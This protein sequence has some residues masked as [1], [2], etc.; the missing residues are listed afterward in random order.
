MLSL[1]FNGHDVALY[2][3]Q[4][5][6]YIKIEKIKKLFYYWQV[7]YNLLPYVMYK[8]VIKKRALKNLEKMPLSVQKKFN[9]LVANLKETGP[10]RQDW[11]NFSK[12][13]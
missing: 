12:L 9:A 6:C 7:V 10:I 3:S 4:A 1:Y 8:V 11:S 2:L 5:K 13:N